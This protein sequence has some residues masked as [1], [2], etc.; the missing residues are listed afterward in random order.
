MV[1][2]IAGPQDEVPQL[3]L[4]RFAARKID[5]QPRSSKLPGPPNV[6]TAQGSQA[7]CPPPQTMN[8]ATITLRALPGRNT[9]PRCQLKPR[10]ATMM[11]CDDCVSQCAVNR[12]LEPLRSVRQWMS[13]NRD[14]GRSG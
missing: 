3:L 1:I 10:Y 12:F 8:R 14:Y 4:L 6:F 11:Q 13:G 2:D 7:S 5:T 9:S